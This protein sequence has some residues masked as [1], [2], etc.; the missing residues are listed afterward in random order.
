MNDFNRS[1]KVTGVH[2]L[3]KPITSLNIKLHLKPENGIALPNFEDFTNESANL[4]QTV[5]A[6]EFNFKWQQKTFSTWELSRYSDIHNCIS[7]TELEYHEIIKDS[8]IEASKVFTYIHEDNYLPTP[9]TENLREKSDGFEGLT[10]CMAK[11]SL[12]GTLSRFVNEDTMSMGRLFRS[13]DN[14]AVDGDSWMSMHVVLDNSEYNEDSQL[15]L[16]QEAVL[17]SLHHNTTRNYVIVSPDV[18]TLEWN[19]YAVETS[20][21]VRWNYVY[22]L[23]LEFDREDDVDDLEI[24]LKKL[25]KKWHSKNKHFLNF[26]M[27]SIGK[28]QYFITF[29]ILSAKDFDADELYVEF[30][31][32]Y[33]DGVTSSDVHHGRTHVTTSMRSE[34][35]PTQAHFAQT[36][37]LQVEADDDHE[38]A[39]IKVFFEVISTDW[40]GRH[41]TEGYAYLPLPLDPGHRTRVLTC[42]RPEEKDKVEAESR[43]F[44]VGGCHLLKDLDVL[45]KPR[46]QNTDFHYASSGTLHLRWSTVAQSTIACRL[47]PAQPSVSSASAV[48]QGAE[49]VLKQYRKARARLAAATRD[50][51]CHDGGGDSW[52][53][54]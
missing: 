17:L 18:N 12:N 41:R 14:I 45:T 38:P 43:R 44:F 22:A 52:V 31:I 28:K 10:S 49:A 54:G 40:W 47:P 11:L 34:D 35:E 13:E 9:K 39:P 48:L 20:T 4:V 51:K 21:G 50:L 27:P 42:V 1:N 23:Q 32:K 15:L 5:D 36:V 33:P 53:N 29:E 30:F 19:P 24:L 3:K 7:D 16:K 6:T 25:K 26:T 8:S 46:M 37:D 2:W